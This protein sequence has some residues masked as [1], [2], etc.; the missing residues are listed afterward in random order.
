MIESEAF[1]DVPFE[2]FSI[3]SIIEIKSYRI[4]QRKI[5]LSGRERERKWTDISNSD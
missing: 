5:K 3:Y 4:F 1:D 2:F